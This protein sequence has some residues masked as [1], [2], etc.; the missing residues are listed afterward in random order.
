MKPKKLKINIRNKVLLILIA[1]IS[2]TILGNFFISGEIFKKAQVEA[3]N[4]EAFATSKGLQTNINTLIEKSFLQYKEIINF[5]TLL[6]NFVI[7]NENILYTYATDE[8]GVVL[9]ASEGAVLDGIG[10]D[11]L[12]QSVMAAR[13]EYIEDIENETLYYI[14]P[15]YDKTKLDDKNVGMAVGVLV[16]AYPRSCIIDPLKRLYA[17]NTILVG[18]TYVFLFTLIFLFLT[19]WITQPLQMLDEVIQSVSK[20]GVTRENALN[21]KSNDEIGQIAK[22]F[23]DMIEQLEATTVSRN[24]INSILVNMSE[25]LFVIDV[26]KR[27][28]IVNDAAINMLGYDREKLQGQI[29]N[30]IYANAMDN[31][32]MRSDISIITEHDLRNIETEFVTADGG[33]IAVSVNWST[34][35]DEKGN[36]YKY[37]CTARDIT[38]IKKAQSIVLYQTNYDELT[39]L[40]NRYNLEKNIEKVICDSGKSHFFLVIDLDRF[41]MVNDICGHAV[42]DKLLK[43]MAYMIKLAMGEDNM[44]ARLSSDEFAVILYDTNEAE[45]IKIV[46]NLLEEI[47]NFNF[48]WEDKAFNIGMSIGAYEINKSGVDRITIFS[49]AD[50]ACYLAKK[51]GGNRLHIYTDQ[52]SELIEREEEASMMPVIVDAF[53]KNRFFLMYQPIVT[54]DDENII[55]AYEVLVR[56]KAKDGTLLLPKVFLPAAERYNMLLSIDKWVIHSFCKNYHFNI[57][58]FA[59]E[60]M[61]FNINISRES[62]MT[63]HFYEYVAKEIEKYNIPAGVLCFEISESCAMTLFL[64]VT[65]LVKKLK[66]IGCNIAI[67]NFGM[68]M[69][70]FMYLKDLLVDTI[71]I[72]GRLINEILKTSTDMTVV[73]SINDIAHLSNI[74][75]VAECVESI[76]VL[77]KVRELGIDYVQ[78]LE[79]DRP[80]EINEFYK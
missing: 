22:S 53:E 4:K 58:R 66:I 17:Y 76:E 34:I 71:K 33:K 32:L 11:R 1:A 43:Q 65:N 10:T 79:I 46:D 44:V 7:N 13:E 24:Y 38:D 61:Q 73:K 72:D 18:F 30:Y 67:D 62:I 60:K 69:S 29:V 56:I 12:M 68:G 28:E 23:N 51:N 39:G 35:N 19:K 74:K 47:R 36:I 45:M 77:E 37:V 9:H 42:G 41:K 2:L 70:S 25:A 27:I 78:G 15:L 52:D 16:V 48:V 80:G 50:R 5:Q 20:R 26:D 8:N 6:D 3:F 54:A 21:I 64:E 57:K 59:H 14:L 75:T 55:C 63:E 49:S 40:Y 31:P